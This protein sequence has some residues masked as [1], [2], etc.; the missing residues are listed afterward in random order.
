M[1]KIFDCSNSDFR[2]EHRAISKGPKQ[3]DI[4]RY[5]HENAKRY[6]CEFTDD[7]KSS[8]VIITN[9]V[10][11]DYVLKIDRPRV[12]RM[13]S[14]YWRTN[15]LDRNIRLNKAAEQSNW[16]IFISQYSW[17]SY[18]YI[19]GYPK[20][21]HNVIRHWVDPKVFKMSYRDT[22]FSL[23]SSATNWS[24]EEKRLS[25]IIKIANLGYKI[26][27]IGEC[28]YNLPSNITK[29][30]YLEDPQE[31]AY[32]LNKSQVFLNLTYRD[33][34]TKT[35]PQAISCGLPV[36]FAQSGGVSEYVGRYGV[37][38]PEPYSIGIGDIIP[39]IPNYD[40]KKLIDNVMHQTVGDTSFRFIEMLK[41]YFNIFKYTIRGYN[42]KH[43]S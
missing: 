15:L 1:I 29:V 17:S 26:N 40:I 22:E 20:F 33:A 19:Y 42:E 8:D 28:E 24:R 34:A 27:L 43:S 30:G 41:S 11:P 6:S 23:V 3:N 37:I 7:Y 5:L 10:Y 12:K 14:P 16:V 21:N 25:E 35:V 31:M 13:C 18:R 9:D 36:I 38:V 32:W 2:P 39:E 4:M